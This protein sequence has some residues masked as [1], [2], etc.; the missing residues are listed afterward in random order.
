MIKLSSNLIL[1]YKE[2]ERELPWRKT[3][4]PYCIWVSEIILQQTRVNQGLTYYNKFIEVFP[5]VH[6]LADANEDT[7][8][9]Y[10]QGLGYYSRARN[11]HF[12]AKYIVNNLNGIFPERYDE[13]LKLKGVGTYTAAAISS[14]C[15]NEHQT[16]VDGNV[17]RV[18][19]RLFGIQTPIN[20]PKGKKEIEELAHE[21]NDGR[22]S[23]IFN[24]AL[25]EFGA[26]Q[27][28][29]KQA[30]C[31]SCI[32][33][34]EC[35]AYLNDLVHILPIKVSKS[36]V[37]NRYL[38]FL[39]FKDPLN[40]VLVQRREFKD[41]WKGLYQ[42]PLIETAI[43]ISVKELLHADDF[44]RL[45]GGTPVEIKSEIKL[46]HLLSHRKLFIKIIELR[47]KSFSQIERSDSLI[48]DIKEMGNYAFPKPLENYLNDLKLSLLNE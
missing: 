15:F 30:D 3:K 7:V 1:W 10:W 36:K 17:F 28:T 46:T 29:P 8:L 19:T 35:Y 5:T 24:Q 40:K 44:I 2:H 9:F 34:S 18:L 33:K 23:G 11:M 43:E 32:F 38:N 20:T 27:C 6:H 41:I 48:L 16:V 26:L 47:I 12:S 14:I 42:F 45:V 39:F 22:Q 31:I 37:Q 21:L 13:L 4:D 25:M